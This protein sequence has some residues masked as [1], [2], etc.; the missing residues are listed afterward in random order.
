MSST[1]DFDNKFDINLNAITA[2][3][4]FEDLQQQLHIASMRPD[5]LNTSN[6]IIT[7]DNLIQTI[8]SNSLPSTMYRINGSMV[9]Q[10][11]M[12]MSK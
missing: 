2:W 1:N 4:S 9:L 5:A 8:G 11:V 6:I 12:L 10:L 7:V 3:K